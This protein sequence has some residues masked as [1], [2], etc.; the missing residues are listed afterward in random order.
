MKCSQQEIDIIQSEFPNLYYDETS[1]KIRGE[2]DFCSKHEKVADKWVVSKCLPTDKWAVEDVFDIEIDMLFPEPRVYEV[3]GRLEPFIY[4]VAKEKIKCEYHF[5]GGSGVRP[6]CCLGKFT[7]NS[8]ETIS[9]FIIRKVHPYFV[10]W[11]FMEKYKKM[12][13][14]GEYSHGLNGQ[15]EFAKKLRTI[16]PNDFC[17]CKS[18]ELHKNCCIGQPDFDECRQ[19]YM[20]KYL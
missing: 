11:G 5:Y 4:L 2:I 8:R 19:I 13:P 1:N 15:I 9:R 12:P 16:M 3:G 6:Y 18:G 14:S 7:P 20:N 17:T 10:W